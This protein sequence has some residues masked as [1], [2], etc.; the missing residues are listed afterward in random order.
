M[1]KPEADLVLAPKTA[2]LRVA[3]EPA[4]NALNSLVMIGQVDKLSGLGDW[5]VETAAA[6]EPHQLR[7]H[8]VVF[9]GLYFALMPDRSHPTFLAYLNDLAATDPVVLRDKIL[10][11]YRYKVCSEDPDATVREEDLGPLLESEDSFITFIYDCFGREHID[12]D[13]E[14]EAYRYLIDPASMQELIVTH[15]R[16]MWEEFLID[17][18]ERTLPTLQESSMAFRKVDF[19]SMTLAE[20]VQYITGRE[21]E[22]KIEH[23]MQEAEQVVFVPSAH[24]GPYVGKY[25][26]DGMLWLV[27]GARMPEGFQTGSTDLRRSDLLVRLSALADDTR[28][29]ILT[30]IREEGEICSQE[31][32]DLLGMSQSSIS[33]HLRQLR[34]TGYLLERRTEQG[35]CFSLNPD[36]IQETL[37]AL[38]GFFENV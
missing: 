29:R 18:W 9:E 4:I 22:E 24:A 37:H 10:D 12:E 25:K 17:E 15:M 1:P 7:A 36:R 23:Y 5:V 19:S 32:I 30:L 35:K 16:T 27:F 34:A 21:M 6:L 3:L 20:A 2:F 8:Q 33:R 38:D 26:G 28:L 14:R 31:L 13:I 11:A